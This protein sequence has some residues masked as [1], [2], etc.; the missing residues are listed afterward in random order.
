MDRIKE[1]FWKILWALAKRAFLTFLA[2][3]IL[4][5][6][7][8]GFIFYKNVFLIKQEQPGVGES[9]LQLK[10]KTLDEVLGEW[11]IRQKK[12]EEVNSKQYPNPFQR[13][14]PQEEKIPGGLTPAL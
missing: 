8:G 10:E 6:I 3:F 1:T 9:P 11:E 5:L 13:P 14:I 2:L 7:I 4:D 12:F